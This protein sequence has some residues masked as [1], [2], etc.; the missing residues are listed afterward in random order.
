MYIIKNKPNNQISTKI[1]TDKQKKI[2]L[3]TL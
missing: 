3:K 1:R 2:F